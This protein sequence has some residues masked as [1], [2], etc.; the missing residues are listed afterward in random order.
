MTPRRLLA[1]LAVFLAVAAAYFLLTWREQRQEQAEQTA[2]RLYQV[3]EADI[4]AVTL[5]KS[6]A[7]IHLEKKGDTWQITRPISAQADKDI[8]HSLLT[9]LASLSQ[10]RDLGQEKNLAPFGLDRPGFL[11]EFT[12]GGKAHGLTVGNA[13]PG[14]Q[15]FYAL[16]DQRKDLL[17]I[18]AADKEA[19]DRPLTA[20]RDKT[21]FAF[22]LD[23]VKAVKV[24][25]D[26]RQEEL[27][28]TAPDRWKRSGPKH[29]KVRADRVESLL[30]RLDMARIKDFVVESPSAKELAAFGLAKPSGAVTI[31]ADKRTETL[32]LGAP[33]KQGLYARKDSAG[34][35]F[36]VEEH[37]RQTIEHTLIGLEDRRLWSG[38]M[39]QVQKVTWGPPDKTW[40]AVREEKAWKLTGP[41]QKSLQPG[42]RL[43]MA[44]V[45]FQDLEY[46]RLAPAANPPEQKTYLF[47][48]GNASG[49][50]LLRLAETGRLEKDQVEVSLERQGN[51]EHALVPLKTYR[52]WQ[53]DLA[54]LTQEPAKTKE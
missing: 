35:V 14:K 48:V 31:E 7:T 4:T 26:S 34:P 51:F 12:A 9:T 5:K 20:L 45:K 36:L 46:T 16:A 47:E 21:L 30:R 39:G 13:T 44:L 1:F 49:Q 22:S 6:D 50:L 33:Q 27:E 54:R 2:K 37:L 19:L 15:G 41:G 40:T 32:F 8:V 17:V 10:D 3:K 29:F 38:E 25:L 28:K 52:E 43:E 53:A 11:A 18:R 42:V 23:K 24:R